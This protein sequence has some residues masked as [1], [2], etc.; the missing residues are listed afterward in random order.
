MPSGRAINPITKTNW[1]GKGIEPHISVARDKALDKAHYTALEK[2][3]EKTDAEARKRSLQWTMEGIKAK[4]A[5]IQVK[6]EILQKYV[7]KYKRGD[8][9]FEKGVLFFK[10]GSKSMKLIPLSETYFV[11]EGKHNVRAEFILDD[12]SKEYKIK[13]HF[14]GGKSE[15]V[16]RLIDRF[17][18]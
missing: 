17:T 14:S 5:P 1:E 11:I 16:N 9:V 3:L 13:A 2:L 15:I 4:F 7:G 8:I 6:E 12:K 10:E 18:L